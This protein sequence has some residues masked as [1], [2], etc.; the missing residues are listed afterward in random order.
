[1]KN[2]TLSIILAGTIM[3]GCLANTGCTSHS[4]REAVT[5]TEDTPWYTN[6]YTD[7]LNNNALEDNQSHVD[8]YIGKL[9][10]EYVFARNIHTLKEGASLSEGTP[11]TD[12]NEDYIIFYDPDTGETRQI[13]I[14]EQAEAKGLISDDTLDLTISNVAINGDINFDLEVM[15]GLYEDFSNYTITV[16]PVTGEFTDVSKKTAEDDF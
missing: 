4:K 3:I 10:G 9:N 13:D 6:E 7:I 1:M 2:K 5:I 12:T 16:D 15:E 11:Y 14:L 8:D